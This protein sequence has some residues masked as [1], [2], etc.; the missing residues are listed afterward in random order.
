MFALNRLALATGES[1]YNQLG[2]QLAK[3]IHPRF[4]RRAE[5]GGLGMVWKLSTDMKAVL[6]PSEGHLD[7]ATGFVVYRLLQQAAGKLSGT[8][9]ELSSEIADYRQL[10]SRE[11]RLKASYDPLDLGMGLW[12]AHF[13]RGEGW[14]GALGNQSLEVTRAVLDESRGLLAQNLA[15]RLAFRE[16]G[17]CLGLKCWGVDEQ[18]K[19]RLKAVI[20]FWQEIV[21]DPTSEDL[22]PI[23]VAMYAAALVPGA[24]RDGYLLLDE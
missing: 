19:K 4:V 17:M 9:D 23:T 8:S 14:A 16:F 2:I 3:A 5:G 20:E 10:M 24:F 11:G 7:A 22:R 12:M 6:V 18:V 15:R 13:F 1:E 21:E